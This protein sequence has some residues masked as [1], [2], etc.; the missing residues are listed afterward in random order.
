MGQRPSF[1]SVIATS[2]A[3]TF[4]NHTALS[5]RFV[6]WLTLHGRGKIYFGTLKDSGGLLCES[7]QFKWLPFISVSL[8][9]RGISI[10]ASGDQRVDQLRRLGAVSVPPGLC[11]FT[12][13]ESSYLFIWVSLAFCTFPGSCP[14]SFI[15]LLPFKKR[16]I[17]QRL[18]IPRDQAGPVKLA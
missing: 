12:T 15:S 8:W 18:Q 13:W 10:L 4:R 11:H 3:F 17:L 1:S 6:F 16:L 2:W 7:P 5:D 14:L 9:T